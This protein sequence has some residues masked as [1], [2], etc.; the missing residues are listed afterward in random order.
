MTS[1]ADLTAWIETTLPF[2]PARRLQI[3]VKISTC[4][5]RVARC[6]SPKS[7]PTSPTNWTSGRVC[8][9]TCSSAEMGSEG[10]LEL[11]GLLE[12]VVGVLEVLDVV[13]AAVRSVAT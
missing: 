12:V 7:R 1:V 9:K 2:I 3:L 8:S 5:S 13:E 10:V 6:L 4:V 11:E